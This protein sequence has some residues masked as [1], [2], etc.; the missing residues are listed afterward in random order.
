M[1]ALDW[2]QLAVIYWY[3]KCVCKCSLHMLHLRLSQFVIHLNPKSVLLA[4][5]LFET[6]ESS[7]YETKM[8]TDIVNSRFGHFR[9]GLLNPILL[10][11]WQWR[12]NQ[13]VFKT[14]QSKPILDYKYFSQINIQNTDRNQIFYLVKHLFISSPRIVHVQGIIP[15]VIK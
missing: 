14:V 11:I 2:C 9:I 6:Q 8:C 5:C 7:E 1:D 15:Y 10:F 3:W 4:V 13:R 12:W